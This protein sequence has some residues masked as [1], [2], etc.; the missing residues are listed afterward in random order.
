[1]RRQLR[2]RCVGDE[3]GVGVRGCGRL[4]EG[5]VRRRGRGRRIRRGYRSTFLRLGFGGGCFQLFLPSPPLC[6]CF[7]GFLRVDRCGL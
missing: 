3:D 1:M 6:F 5:G 4:L 2:R 7:I